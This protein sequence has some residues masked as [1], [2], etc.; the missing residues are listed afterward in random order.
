MRC[1][2]IGLLCVQ[3]KPEDRPTMSSVVI[4]LGN[5]DAPFLEPKT[6]GFKAIF[7]T[8]YDSTLNQ[9]DLHTFNIVTLT[10]PQTGR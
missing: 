5:D 3:K 6:P 7:S 10:E 2:N 1:V 4:M 9:T 8:K